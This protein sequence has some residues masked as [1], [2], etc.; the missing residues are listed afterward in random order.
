MSIYS[1]LFTDTDMV[2]D[3]SSR[4]AIDPAVCVLF[5]QA[6]CAHSSG[7]FA[8]NRLDDYRLSGCWNWRRRHHLIL[9]FAVFWMWK[10]SYV[11]KFDHFPRLPTPTL[12]QLHWLPVCRLSCA[13]QTFLSMHGIANSL[14]PVFCNKSG[15]RSSDSNTFIKSRTRIRVLWI[16]E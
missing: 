1:S 16:V 11:M 15:S 4:K 12:C 14:A 10:L 5:A 9:S 3:G 2:D 13:V 8:W 6:Q 7:K